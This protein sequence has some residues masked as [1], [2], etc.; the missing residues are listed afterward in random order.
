MV[1][2]TRKSFMQSMLAAG[3]APL[4]FG[5]CAGRFL[6][7]RRVN[8]AIIGCGRIA[9]SFE[10]P[11][12]LARADLARIVAVCDLDSKRAAFSKAKIE[13]SYADGTVIRTYHDYQEV[14]ACPDI[15]AVMICLPDF[16]HAL[17]ATT[18]ICSGKAVWLQKPFTQTIREGRIL[19]NLA[20]KYGT[21][22]QVGSQQR[23]WNNFRGVCEAVQAGVI[24][25]VKKVEIGLGLDVAGGCRMAEPVPPNFDYDTWLGPTDHSVP[26]NWTRCHNQDTKRIGDRPGWIQLAPY[27]WGLITNWGAHHLDICRWGLGGAA[28][29][30]VEGAC[31]WMDMSGDK[32]WNVHTDYDLHYRFNNGFTD[33]H[34]C[35]RYQLGIKFI[36]EGGDWLFCTRGA[37]KVTPSDPEPYVRPGDLGPLAVSKPSLMPK[38]R[39]QPVSA[40]QAHVDDWLAAVAANDPSMTVTN[41]EGGHR[42]TSLCLLGQMCMELGRGRKDGFRLAWDAKTESTGNAA[43]DALMK[44]FAS[45]KFDLSVNLAEFG[46]DFNSVMKG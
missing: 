13:K 15:D 19:A 25:K 24:G 26:Y 18:A 20:K 42:S 31:D 39:P 34:L 7:N 21:V 5:G 17:V 45:G 40:M 22:L 16:W 46:L 12:V 2:V 35:N 6:A 9:N 4:L 33:V 29:E 14:C 10:I 3:S 1:Q 8:V 41:A 27:G 30:G 38:L 23:S 37:A 44:P 32:L 36:G 43:A 28:P 11:G